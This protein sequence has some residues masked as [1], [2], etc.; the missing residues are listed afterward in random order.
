M[1]ISQKCSSAMRRITS[2][3]KSGGAGS[4]KNIASLD[5]LRAFAALGVVT[6]HITYLVGYIIVNEYK[7]PWLASFWVFGNTGVQLFFVLSGF[8]LFMPYA[9][10]LLLGR[11]LPSILR[12]YQRRALRILP[13]CWDCLG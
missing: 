10:A 3:A 9:K 7:D 8:L 5:G 12:F 6:L 1:Q 2:D 13:A 11:P 4:K